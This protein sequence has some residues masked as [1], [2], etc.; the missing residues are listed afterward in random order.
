VAGEGISGR[1]NDINYSLVL[2]LLLIIEQ[3]N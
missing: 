2:L 1:I 3:V